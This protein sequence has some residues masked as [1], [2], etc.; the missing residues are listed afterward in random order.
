MQLMAQKGTVETMREARRDFAQKPSRL[1]KALAVVTTAALV[2]SMTAAPAFAEP[3]E[4]TVPGQTQADQ[5]MLL[6]I[7]GV[8]FMNIN[9]EDG[10]WDVLRVE[11]GAEKSIYIE[12]EKDGKPFVPR[13][14]YQI[15]ATQDVDGEAA[16]DNLGDGN[17]PIAQIVSLKVAAAA[18]DARQAPAPQSLQQ[19]FGDHGSFPSYTLSVYSAK[20]GGEQLYAGTIYPVYA[21]L[22]N[23]DGTEEWKLL[24][25]RTRGDGD[26][27]ADTIGAGT[28]YYKNIGSDQPVAY[29][30]EN[31]TAE[32]EPTVMPEAD[33]RSYV[34]SYKQVPTDA[35]SGALK[36]VDADG[37]IIDTEVVENIGTGKEVAVKKSFFKPD[38]SVGGGITIIASFSV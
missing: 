8:D 26:S 13:F 9:G 11:N 30:C 34:V 6:T 29:Q 3:E 38:A 5:E 7:H 1:R 19:V 33:G 18:S 35:I 20:R 22:V 12:I 15:S 23:T 4:E 14:A 27:F 28:S 21:K 25:I 31:A 2:V 24:G 16:A 37:T 10:L 17:N 36:Y 32:G